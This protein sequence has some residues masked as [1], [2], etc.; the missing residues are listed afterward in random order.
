MPAAQARVAEVF[1]DHPEEA[2]RSS[3]A[4]LAGQAG[5]GEASVIR[6]CRTIGFDNLRDLRVALAAETAYRQGHAPSSEI[7]QVDRLCTAL[8]STAERLDRD[9]LRRVAAAM[10]AA[11]HIDVF[12]SGVSGMGAHLFAYRFSRIGLVARAWSDEVVVDEILPSR[13]AGSVAMIVSET[14]LTLRT[15]SFLKKSRQAGAFTV[16]ICSQ[17]AD[18][19]EP[20]CDEVLAVAPLDPLPERGEM[21]PLLGKLLLCDRIAAEVLAITN[22]GHAGR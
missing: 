20:L 2:I 6:F 1:L 18:V 11:P 15:E 22:N 19:L 10:K 16:A 21:A 3:I 14:G 8:R 7:D 9:A 5:C 12:G 4:D 17:S 13:R